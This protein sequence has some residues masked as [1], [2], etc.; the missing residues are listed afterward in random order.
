M[1]RN[2]LWGLLLLGLVG[3]GNDHLE[4]MRGNPAEASW[5]A[6]EELQTGDD[7]LMLAA[8]AIDQKDW[9][10]PTEYLKGPAFEGAIKK[11]EQ[12]EFP[13]EWADRA[14]AKNDV[15]TRLKDLAETAKTSGGQDKLKIGWE[16]PNQVDR[17]AHDR[18]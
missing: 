11:F 2:A 12:A 6:L 9:R 3:C 10:G 14:E 18:H 15:V 8:Q 16:E 4:K 5:A 17:R 13:G 7:E 1:L